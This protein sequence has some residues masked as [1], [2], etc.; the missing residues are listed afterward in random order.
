MKGAV[1]S[2]VVLLLAFGVASCS[3]QQP[4]GSTV[5]LIVRHAEKT[6]EAE[7]SPLTEAGTQRAQALAGVAAE[8]GVSAVYTTQFRRNRDTAQPLAERLSIKPTEVAV[9]LQ[10]PGDYGKRLAGDIIEKHRGQTVLVVGHG[11]TIAPIV[12]GLTGR[13]A[14]V[15]DV[16]YGDLL[17]V[18][19]PPSGTA[20][21]IKA[22]Y[23]AGAA[24]NNMMKK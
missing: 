18:T 4:Q 19:V 6:S 9:N 8:A 21:L 12:E 16:Q 17:I 24:G 20:R 1:Q 3:R 7:D 22:Q 13:A 15:G 11:N 23:G 2:L 14:A 10:N 5:V